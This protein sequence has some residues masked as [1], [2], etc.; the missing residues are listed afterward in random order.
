MIPATSCGP[1]PTIPDI[2]C[3]IC[4]WF[5]NEHSADV[6][7]IYS[8]VPYPESESKL[9][10]NLLVL[11]LNSLNVSLCRLQDCRPGPWMGCLPQKGQRGVSTLGTPWTRQHHT[12]ADVDHTHRHEPGILAEFSSDFKWLLHCEPKKWETILLSISLPRI[13]TI[14]KFFYW[15][16]FYRG[17]PNLAMNTSA[18]YSRWRTLYITDSQ[19]LP[20]I[21]EPRT[22]AEC[23]WINSG[24]SL[25]CSPRPSSRIRASILQFQFWTQIDAINLPHQ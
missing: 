24:R 3:T 18:S 10:S 15:R 7:V 22:L 2:R 16:T 6:Y 20:S 8:P 19:H 17:S 1:Y 13:E 25:Q 14:W 12:V 4:L 11:K 23:S 21:H 9:G 5:P